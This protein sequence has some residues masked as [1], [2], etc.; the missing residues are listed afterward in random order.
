MPD[1]KLSARLSLIASL[2]PP[3]SS[4]V[5]VGTDHGYI[6]VY[7]ALNGSA[8]KI[9]ATDINEAP[10]NKAVETAEKFGVRDRIDFRLGNGL[11]CVLPDNADLFRSLHD[12]V[13]VLGKHAP[14]R[15]FQL[16]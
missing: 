2:V 6:P 12:K 7:L 14:I 15:R 10:L 1:I 3:G 9:T 4:V 13:N 5:D 16:R 8:E 11:E